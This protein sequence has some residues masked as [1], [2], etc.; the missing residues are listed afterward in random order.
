[1]IDNIKQNKTEVGC[2]VCYKPAK[3]PYSFREGVNIIVHDYCEEHYPTPP[4][5]FSTGA[6][7]PAQQG[8]KWQTEIHDA[9]KYNT[10]LITNEPNKCEHQFVFSHKSAETV[11]VQ[12]IY[13][14]VIYVICPKCGLVKWQV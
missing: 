6:N 14:T 9:D 7:P 1:M 2:N 13:Q 3:A 12:A 11:G 8:S 5:Q 10:S 4:P